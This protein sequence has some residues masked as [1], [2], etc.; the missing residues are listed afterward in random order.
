MTRSPVQSSL[1]FSASPAERCFF[2]FPSRTWWWSNTAAATSATSSYLFIYFPLSF[3]GFTMKQ[4]I[5]D[6]DSSWVSRRSGTRRT[7]LHKW[8]S[9][10]RVPNYV[11]TAFPLPTN[12]HICKVMPPHSTCS[13]QVWNLRETPASLLRL[14]Q[15]LQCSSEMQTLE[16]AAP[17]RPRWTSRDTFRA[18]T[19]RDDS[20]KSLTVS[21]MQKQ[22]QIFLLRP[23]VPLKLL[24]NSGWNYLHKWIYHQQCM[25]ADVTLST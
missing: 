16:V 5:G 23:P 7:L 22:F 8:D 12:V 2:F 20:F 13:R 15:R 19:R 3:W 10:L 24:K 21:I 1:L 17:T 4:M 14:L 18:G 9:L 11:F 6:E 25:T